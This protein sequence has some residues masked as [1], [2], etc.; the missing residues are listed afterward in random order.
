MLSAQADFVCVV[1]TSSRPIFFKHPLKVLSALRES[2]KIIYATEQL[3]QYGQVRYQ[4]DGEWGVGSG[5]WGE[6]GNL[7]CS[8]LI[9]NPFYQLR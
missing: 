1:A 2:Q 3:S 6:K 4:V 7:L 5:E 8:F 9:P